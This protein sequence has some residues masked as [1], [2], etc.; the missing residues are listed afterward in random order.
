MKNFTKEEIRITGIILT[1][2]VVVSLLNFRVA[3][4]RGRDA[5]RKTS[6][7]EVY[8]ALN[9]YQNDFGFFP[10]S[11]TDG[12]IVAC[13]RED[14]DYEKGIS[15]STKK[16]RSE[17]LLE[18]FAPCEWGKDSLADITDPTY[19]SY[20]STLPK[21]PYSQKGGFFYV[22][23]TEEFQLY[24]ALEGK[25]EAEYDESITFLGLSCGE[26]I[27]NFGKATGAVPL[28]KTLEEYENERRPK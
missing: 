27:C 28:D 6:L 5:D 4:R 22:S 11:T 17:L 16:T 10:P 7:G 19:P 1:V 25:N 24:G 15:L 21:D 26:R 13:K 8:S 9:Q 14:I 12:K 2:L 18:I 23:N 3:L 20:I